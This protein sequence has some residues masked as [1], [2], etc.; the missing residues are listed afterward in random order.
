MK[1]LIIGTAFILAMSTT[2]NAYASFDSAAYGKADGLNTGACQ[3]IPPARPSG[4]ATMQRIQAMQRCNIGVRQ[5]PKQ[6]NT[7]DGLNT[8]ACQSI[9]SARPSGGATMQRIQ[10]MQRCNTGVR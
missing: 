8:G 10:A 2:S 1:T 7:V 5:F 6:S 3:S 9:P 4:G